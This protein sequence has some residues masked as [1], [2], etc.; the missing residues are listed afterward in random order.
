MDGQIKST[1]SNLT[2]TAFLFCSLMVERLGE[3]REDVGST[4]IPNVLC[5][6]WSTRLKT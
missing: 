2:E 6:R 5:C 3:S 4:P 1:N